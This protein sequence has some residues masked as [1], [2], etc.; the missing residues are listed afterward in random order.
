MIANIYEQAKTYVFNAITFSSSIQDNL[1]FSDRLALTEQIL[2][3][4]MVYGSKGFNEISDGDFLGIWFLGMLKTKRIAEQLQ[5]AKADRMTDKQFYRKQIQDC[6]ADISK[7]KWE[8]K[9]EDYNTLWSYCN[10][11]IAN[12]KEILNMKNISEVEK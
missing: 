5:Q 6:I 2:A 8:D 4:R 9:Q 11:I 1:I 10:L 12:I 7:F 3:E